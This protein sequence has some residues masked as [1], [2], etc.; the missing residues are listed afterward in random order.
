M[1]KHDYV[2]FEA[3]NWS[4]QLFIKIGLSIF[5]NNFVSF[6]LGQNFECF[7]SNEV[8]KQNTKVMTESRHLRKV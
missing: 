2:R 1:L 7:V 6:Y 5:I 4:T 3:K 8:T